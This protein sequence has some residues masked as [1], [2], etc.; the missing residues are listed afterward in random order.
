MTCNII[1]PKQLFK[2]NPVP[3]QFNDV[4]SIQKTLRLFPSTQIQN[5]MEWILFWRDRISPSSEC[6]LKMQTVNSSETL[7]PRPHVI[8]TNT[9]LCIFTMLKT[10][11]KNPSGWFMQE[12][13]NYQYTLCSEPTLHDVM[14]LHFAPHL[15]YGFYCLIKWNNKIKGYN[16]TKSCKP[17]WN[18]KC[19]ELY[20][21]RWIY[22]QHNYPRYMQLPKQKPN[23]YDNYTYHWTWQILTAIIFHST[24]DVHK[25]IGEQNVFWILRSTKMILH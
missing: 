21:C 9:T 4:I 14:L 25:F 23:K 1:L 5:N 6:L 8:L 13:L 3:L 16:K 11:S 7:L 2:P 24:H 15:S 12:K 19:Y 20:I 10:W 18:A 17:F 22:S